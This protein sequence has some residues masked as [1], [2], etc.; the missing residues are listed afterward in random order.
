M[1][2][3]VQ[4]LDIALSHVH[5]LTAADIV[6]D[7]IE[8]PDLQG[9][10]DSLALSGPSPRRPSKKGARIAQN[11]APSSGQ[12]DLP[13]PLFYED[14]ILDVLSTGL[15]LS[16]P[17]SQHHHFPAALFPRSPGFDAITTTP[18]TLDYDYQRTD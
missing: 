18:Q 14:A 2:G 11:A 3:A 13:A 5:E 10:E 7:E 8:S 1:R 12:A 4:K 17:V 16:S 15:L 6:G 9:A